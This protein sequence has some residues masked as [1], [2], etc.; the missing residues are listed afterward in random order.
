MKKSKGSSKSGSARKKGLIRNKV[1][2]KKAAKSKVR[3]RPAAK[4]TAAKQRPSKKTKKKEG[5]RPYSGSMRLRVIGRGEGEILFQIA[6]GNNLVG[7]WDPQEGAFPEIDLEQLDREAKISRKHCVI[8]RHGTSATIEDVGS[9]N[10]T[11]INQGEQ[12]R[13][14]HPHTLQ[15]GDEILV[16]K[17]LLRF[18]AGKSR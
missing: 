15:D 8:E 18:E 11:Y 6:P 12:L 4:R 7:R 16:G 9:L 10:G 17:V 3:T 2:K 1:T 13:P 5:G 14:G